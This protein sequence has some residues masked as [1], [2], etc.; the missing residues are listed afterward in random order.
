MKPVRHLSWSFLPTRL[1]AYSPK[2]FSQKFPPYMF[3]RVINNTN[4]YFDKSYSS[5][6]LTHPLN[7]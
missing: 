1:M 4:F 6:I 2:Q 3:E 5:Q 7:L